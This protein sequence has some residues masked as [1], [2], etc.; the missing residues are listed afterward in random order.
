MTGSRATV[1]P[2]APLRAPASAIGSFMPASKCARWGD[3]EC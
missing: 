3:L 1:C 2:A